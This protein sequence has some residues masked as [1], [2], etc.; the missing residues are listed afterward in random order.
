MPVVYVLC[1]SLLKNHTIH[2]KQDIV[3][4]CI[5]AQQKDTLRFVMQ[6][7]QWCLLSWASCVSAFSGTVTSQVVLDNY[8]RDYPETSNFLLYGNIEQYVQNT[9]PAMGITMCEVFVPID[10]NPTLGGYLILTQNMDGS[11][12][13]T[14]DTMTDKDKPCIVG[15]NFDGALF[16]SSSDFNQQSFFEYN[17]GNGV[18]AGGMWYMKRQGNRI[19]LHDE[20]W[21]YCYKNKHID[22]VWKRIAYIEYPE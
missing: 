9:C 8:T 12:D 21:N 13:F 22:D 18:M 1:A 10:D 7:L 20:R 2:I 16:D 17:K 4:K 5:M 11:V 15:G 3:G 19:Q 14:T 6:C